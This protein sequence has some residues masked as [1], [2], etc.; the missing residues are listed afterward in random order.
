MDTPS[1]LA[2]YSGR[3]DLYWLQDKYSPVYVDYADISSI[4]SLR[5]FGDNFAAIRNAPTHYI[6]GY[7]DDSLQILASVNSYAYSYTG[8][9]ASCPEVVYPYFFGYSQQTNKVVMYRYRE[10]ERDF[11]FIDS[12]NLFEPGYTFTQ[13]YG[14]KDR[15]FTRER[16]PVTGGYEIYEKTFSTGNDTLILISSLY[17]FKQTYFIDEID[18]TDSLI[19]FNGTYTTLNGQALT[20][21]G[22]NLLSYSNLSG[23]RIYNTRRS[24]LPFY[25]ALFYSTQISG[26]VINSSRFYYDPVG[27]DDEKGQIKEYRLAQ[28]YPNPFNPVTTI[29]YTLPEA[30]NVKITVYNSL[31][32]Q[33][34]VLVDEYKYPGNH[35]VNF[36]AKGIVSGLY[37]Y[38]LESGAYIQTKKMILLK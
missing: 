11:V 38:K 2:L 13:M 31:G 24:G 4:I 36:D 16:K 15:F 10:D 20:D 28:N 9:T 32:E 34:R 1:Y 17:S 3:V 7:L 14:G 33:I 12:L 27:V 21:P 19:R 8:I 22:G 25:S 37:F 6:I 29:N 18:C 5:P 26:N 23:Y 35:T 30:G